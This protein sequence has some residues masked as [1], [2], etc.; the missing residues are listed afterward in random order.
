MTSILNAN[1]PS[2]DE[3]D[4]DYEPEVENKESDK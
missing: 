3:E 2:E 1:L 4:I